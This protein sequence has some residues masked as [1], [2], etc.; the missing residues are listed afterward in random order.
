[1]T[2]RPETLDIVVTVDG[3]VVVAAE[4]DEIVE[5]I[6]A[7]GAAGGDV[8]DADLFEAVLIAAGV[9][10]GEVVADIGAHSLFLPAVGAAFADAQGGDEDGEGVDD[11]AKLK[12]DGCDVEDIGDQSCGHVAARHKWPFLKRQESAS[13]GAE[14]H[15][16]PQRCR[17]FPLDADSCRRNSI[18]RPNKKAA[19]V[20]LT[21]RCS[22]NFVLLG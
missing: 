8:V 17:E 16:T 7:A 9:L 14:Q 20:G 18:A 12:G 4:G 22:A 2:T 3:L 11:G 21:K 13:K 1:M 6:G 15:F 10:A 19:V 5:V